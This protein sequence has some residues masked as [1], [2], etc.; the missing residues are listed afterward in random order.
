[1]GQKRHGGTATNGSRM[2]DPRIC[3]IGSG[4][5]GLT[6]LKN[7]LALGLTNVACFDEADAI[8]GNWVF[9]EDKPSVHEATH[10]ISSKR[11]S[12]FEDY[13]MPA[14]YPDFPSHREI[15]AYFEAYAGHFR[16][17]PF[18]RLKQRIESAT[19]RPDGSWLVRIAT[20]VW[21]PSSTA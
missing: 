7:L 12:E 18:I 11:L 21:L 5:S 2:D 6:T 15:R 9:R 1:M 13:P 14:D 20:S 17:T 3:I 19:R 10:I 8:G 16:L 4:P